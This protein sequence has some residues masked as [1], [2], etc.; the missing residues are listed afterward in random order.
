MIDV[1]ILN[2]MNIHHIITREKLTPNQGFN[3]ETARQ[4]ELYVPASVL[5]CSETC[6]TRILVQE[7][8][9]MG[10]TNPGISPTVHGGQGDCIILLISPLALSFNGRII[11]GLDL[12]KIME[13]ELASRLGGH[14]V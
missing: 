2:D 9:A 7:R 14:M 8:K 12:G 3:E 5:F 11:V 10:C 6:S 13:R 1:K 4:K